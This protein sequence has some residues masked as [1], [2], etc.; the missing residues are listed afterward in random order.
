MALGQFPE[1]LGFCDFFLF[2]F[3]W[4]G[5]WWYCFVCLFLVVTFTSF[6]YSVE[7]CV[8]RAAYLYRHPRIRTLPLLSKYIFF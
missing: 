6:A 5:G 8:Y 1:T 2:L 4:G 7:E 3:F